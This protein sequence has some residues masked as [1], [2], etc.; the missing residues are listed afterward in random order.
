MKCKKTFIQLNTLSF[1]HPGGHADTRV[2]QLLN[3]FAIYQV[4]RITATDNYLRDLFL[5]DEIGTGR[6]F[7]EMCA[8]LQ[9]NI[10]PA[11][12]KYFSNI[13]AEQFFDL[14]GTAFRIPDAVHF[15]MRLTVPLVI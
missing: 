13:C 2:A 14:T 5:N 10:Y 1:Q 4:K 11:L 6:R 15:S 9:G 12:P 7:T 3:A 8:W